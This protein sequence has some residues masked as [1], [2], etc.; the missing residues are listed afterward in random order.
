[1]PCKVEFKPNMQHRAVLV[2]QG[3]FS[4]NVSSNDSTYFKGEVKAVEKKGSFKSLDEEENT[5]YTVNLLKEF[6]D[7]A[8]DVLNRHPVNEERR[9]KGLLPANYLLMRGP[10]IEPPKLKFYRNWMAV[11][12]TPLEIGFSKVS[13]MKVFP[14]EY[15]V[16]KGIDSYL[17]LR[18][19]LKKICDYSIKMIKKNHKKSDYALIHIK[20]TDFPG[21]DNKPFEKKQ[22]L[23]HIDK[24]LFKFLRKFA[25]P[26]K[27]KIV[28]TGDHSTPCRLKSHSA[29]P[30]PVLIYNV[31]PPKTKKIKFPPMPK[32]PFVPKK[33]N[34][35]GKEEVKVVKFC[36]K[37][38]RKGSLGIFSGK[39]LLDKVG[40]LK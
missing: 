23:E 2:L 31:S 16:L 14:L 29:D 13:G 37:N 4:D 34:E 7:K 5:Q 36:E 9:K 24:T 38:A 19:G 28:V 25:P 18:E 30:V 26:K 11:S 3:G 40:F 6:T 32:I 35:K 17:N 8:F 27:I 33:E 21:H 15:P 39:Q 22:M 20:E 12:S 10:G 1:M